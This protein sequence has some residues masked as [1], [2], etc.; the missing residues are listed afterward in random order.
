MKME[1]NVYY[2]NMNTEKIEALNVFDHC[3]FRKKKKKICRKFNDKIMFAEEVKESAMYF[4]WCRSEY[5]I[6]ITTFPPQITPEEFDRLS[7]ID[8]KSRH[9]YGVNLKRATKIDI[10]CQLNLNWEHFIDYIWNN[11]EKIA[12]AT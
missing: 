6:V 4:F 1:W 7:A 12:A 2:V 3:G 10:Y 8:N 9:T 5:E 11:K